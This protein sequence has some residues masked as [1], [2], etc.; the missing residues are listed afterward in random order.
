MFNIRSEWYFTRPKNLLFYHAPF[1]LT[2]SFKTKKEKQ[3]AQP[4]RSTKVQA[5]SG[6]RDRNDFL[7]APLSKL[8]VLPDYVCQG[9]RKRE[10]SSNVR[11]SLLIEAAIPDTKS[12]ISPT[13][14]KHFAVVTY[15]T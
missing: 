3:A 10:E 2:R 14:A 15:P 12:L 1:D 5:C 11:H 4:G 9:E 13:L 8:C 6:Y 7:N